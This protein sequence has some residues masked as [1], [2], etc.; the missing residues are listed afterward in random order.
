MTLFQYI[1]YLIVGGNTV[2]KTFHTG[3]YFMN[4]SL[5]KISE[6]AL[7]LPKTNQKS[8]FS[9]NCNNYLFIY[10]FFKNSRYLPYK[11]GRSKK[12]CEIN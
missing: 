3:F 8:K 6:L 4:F 10:R 5:R 7:L 12:T 11:F 2:G 9:K 1:L